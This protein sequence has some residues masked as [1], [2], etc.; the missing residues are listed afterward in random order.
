MDSLHLVNIPVTPF[1]SALV[2]ELQTLQAR[3]EKA[4]ASFS[5]GCPHAYSVFQH[6][7][8]LWQLYR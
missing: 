4:A 8:T 7:T 6:S 5:S 3:F 2:N 1:L